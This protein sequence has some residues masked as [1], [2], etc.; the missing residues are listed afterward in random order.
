M[1]GTV[2]DQNDLP[3]GSL[4]AIDCHAWTL[5]H[6]ACA[7]PHPNGIDCLAKSILDRVVLPRAWDPWLHSKS[8]AAFGESENALQSDTIH[9][10]RRASIPRPS[11]SA[12]VSLR[13]VNVGR[14]DVRLHLVDLHR[15]GI[16]RIYE[17]V[18]HLKELEGAIT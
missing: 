14:N 11:S 1:A 12:E 6:W 7:L 13:G 9:P 15:G 18:D 5:D 10:A 8:I 2:V 16:A 3:F 4:T 17:G